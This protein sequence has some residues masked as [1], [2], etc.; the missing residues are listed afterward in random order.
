MHTA[1]SAHGPQGP[2]KPQL[3]PSALPV[4]LFA[5]GIKLRSEKLPS[6][7]LP[8]PSYPQALSV[9]LPLAQATLRP[10]PASLWA[11]SLVPIPTWHSSSFQ[12]A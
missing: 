12:L 3:L 7:L 9:V 8:S 10:L 5:Q 1:C 6:T 4:R 11:L 2:L